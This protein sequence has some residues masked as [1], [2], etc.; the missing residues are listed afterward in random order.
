MRMSGSWRSKRSRTRERSLLRVSYP[1]T[2]QDAINARMEAV[3]QEF[4]DE[5]RTTRRRDRGGL[6]GIQGKKQEERQPPLSPTTGSTLTFQS[7]TK[8]S[9]SSTLCDQFIQ[10]ARATAYAVGYIFDRRSGAELSIPD[11]FVDDSYLERLSTLTREV[12]AERVRKEELASGLEWVE[13]GTSPI[14]EN[15]DNHPVS[16]GRNSCGH[17]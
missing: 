1:I 8:T 6:S 2:E 3:T 13:D 4:I 9:F 10:V 15:F 7:L 12:L 14:A 17:V 16:R 11:L 5:Y